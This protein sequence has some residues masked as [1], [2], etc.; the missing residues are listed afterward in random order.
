MIRRPPRSTQSRSSAASD[1]YKRQ[2]LRNPFRFTLR[3]GT[4][5]IWVGDVGQFTH[6]EVNRIPAPRS[7]VVPNFGWPCYEGAPRS[8]R[9]SSLGLDLCNDLYAES[10]AEAASAPWFSYAHIDDVVAG[11]TC[12][13]GAGDSV[14]GGAFYDGGAY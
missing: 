5:E 10:G 1:V 3:P 7:G 6:E 14:T 11:E 13:R 12:V 9:F 4:A 8:S 2:G